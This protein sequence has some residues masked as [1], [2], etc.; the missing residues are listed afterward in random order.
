[1]CI[2]ISIIGMAGLAAVSLWGMWDVLDGQWDGRQP[3]MGQ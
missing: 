2:A 3:E 1:M